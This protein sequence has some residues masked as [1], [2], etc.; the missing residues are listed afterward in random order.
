LFPLPAILTASQA[1]CI[2]SFGVELVECLAPA[3][4]ALAFDE[5]MRIASMR[6]RP[7][8]LLM[9]LER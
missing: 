4:D 1:P 5:A 3:Q 7:P 2:G 8:T 6:L 9:A